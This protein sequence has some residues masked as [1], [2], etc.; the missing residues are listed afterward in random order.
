MA[1]HLPVYERG[2]VAPALTTKLK[3]ARWWRESWRNTFDYEATQLTSVSTAS[4]SPLAS[5]SSTLSLFVS[6]SLYMYSF[7]HAATES[8]RQRQRESREEIKASRKKWPGWEELS[9][10]A[11]VSRS[12]LHGHV[13]LLWPSK[14]RRRDDQAHPPRRQLRR[15][16]TGHFRRLRP[17]HQRNPSRQG[18]CCWVHFDS[19]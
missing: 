14:A 17:P 1:V 16:L 9:S 6:L 3:S 5:W 15:Q 7:I 4:P 13:H 12:R 8:K 19:M 2:S 10:V 11:K 18:T